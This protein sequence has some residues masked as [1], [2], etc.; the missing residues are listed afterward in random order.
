MR[1]LEALRATAAEHGSALF[2]DHP[3]AERLVAVVRGE[4]G[5]EETA[6][7]R[8]HLAVC[9]TCATEWR[10]IAGEA[11]AADGR[12]SRPPVGRWWA[13]GAAA[14][15]VVLTGFLLLPGGGSEPDWG[16]PD[17]YMLAAEQRSEIDV[18]RIEVSRSGRPLLLLLEADLD[19]T[20]FPLEIEISGPGGRVAYRGTLGQ[21]DHLQQSYLPLVL[22]PSAFAPGRYVAQLRPQGSDSVPIESRF[23]VVRSPTGESD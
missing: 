22:D 16:P 11:V 2:S 7:T 21:A 12:G 3:D 10:W 5:E 9:A 6:E 23:E 1:E 20:A 17:T 15:A 8:R 18:P 13:I 14:A 19:A 4:A